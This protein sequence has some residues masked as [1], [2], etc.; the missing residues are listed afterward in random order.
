MAAVN[1]SDL[2][3]GALIFV[4][5]YNFFHSGFLGK[6]ATYPHS[7]G[8]S[9][10]IRTYLCGTRLRKRERILLNTGIEL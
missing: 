2:T 4:T 8:Y 7:C 10:V 6:D 1:N 9:C 5:D 3:N